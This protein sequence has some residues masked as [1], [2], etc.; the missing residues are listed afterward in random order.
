MTNIDFAEWLENELDKREIKP[1]ELARI[2][3]IDPGVVTRILK[4]ERSARPKTLESIAH[5]LRLPPEFVF[6]KAGILPPKPELTPIKR[7]LLHLAE[8]LPDSDIELA[9]SILEQRQDYY[10][11]NPQAKPVK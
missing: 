6:E 2:A 7:K 10:K 5:A 8:G 4:A 1:V 11:K 9:L 3:G